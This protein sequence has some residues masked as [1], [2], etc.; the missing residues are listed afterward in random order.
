MNIK[1]IM[2]PQARLVSPETSIHQAAE[3]MRE[4]GIG[5]LL[6]GE[7]DRLKG[8]LTDRDIVIRVVAEGRDIRNT[9]VSDILTDKVLYCREDQD[10][11]E[12]ARNMSEQQVRRMPVVSD[13]KR[14]VGV[15]SIG[16]LAQ[17][18]SAETAGRVLQ[19]VT[20]R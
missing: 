14:L 1:D 10:A 3:S 12:V 9:R 18:L 17:H 2:N 7:N 6:V 13:N 5:F 8:T 19:G 11:S 16:D 15:I 4:Q 20:A